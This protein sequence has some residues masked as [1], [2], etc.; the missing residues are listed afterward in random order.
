MFLFSNYFKRRLT[1]DTK[2]KNVLI[3]ML[4]AR[5]NYENCIG[6]RETI[7]LYLSTST[8]GKAGDY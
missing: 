4:K 5:R 3:S 8:G 6:A 2:Q 7:K 1:I